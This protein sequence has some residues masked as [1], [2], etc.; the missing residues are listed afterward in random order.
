[1][2]HGYQ[3]QAA[4]GYMTLD[5]LGSTLEELEKTRKAAERE[6]EALRNRKGYLK[7]LEHDRDELLVALMRVAPGALDLLTPEQRHQFYKMLR[8]KVTIHPDGP[9]EMSWVGAPETM[10]AFGGNRDVCG[11]DTAPRCPS[12]PGLCLSRFYFGDFLIVRSTMHRG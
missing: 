3:E 6:L 9:V 1:M 11:L 8:L 2:R 4:K 10:L 12:S 7:Q 5:E